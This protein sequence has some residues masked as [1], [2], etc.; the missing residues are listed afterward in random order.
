MRLYTDFL[1]SKP[2]KYNWSGV[3]GY[4]PETPGLV[5]LF[6]EMFAVISLTSTKEFDLSQLGGLLFDELQE[7]YFKETQAKVTF[8]N[9]EDAVYKVKARLE[10]ILQREKELAEVGVDMEMGVV[11]LR[12]EYLYGAIV[13]ETR[14]FI[15]RQGNFAEIAKS[16][17]DPE[18][19]GFMRSGSLV[20]EEDDRIFLSTHKLTAD[21]GTDA[22]QVLTNFK[23]SKLTPDS[24]A[25]LVIGYELAMEPNPAEQD[26]EEA[27]ALESTDVLVESEFEPSTLNAVDDLDLELQPEETHLDA[28]ESEDDLKIDYDED[29]VEEQESVVDVVR[30]SRQMPVDE[31][32]DEEYDDDEYEEVPTW[33][34]RFAGL[35]AKAM[36]STNALRAK[37][38][39]LSGKL[40]EKL[41]SSDSSNKVVQNMPGLDND[42]V[43]PTLAGSMPRNS[44]SYTDKAKNLLADGQKVA[45]NLFAQVQ[46]Q[47]SSLMGNKPGDRQMYLRGRQ[48]QQKWK[49][50]AIVGF[51]IAVALFLIIRRRGE[52]AEIARQI[53]AVETQISQLETQWNQTKA[54]VVTTSVASADAAKLESLLSS[55]NTIESKAKELQPKNIQTDKIVRL[56]DDTETSRNELLNIRAFTEPQV[57][58]DL[59]AVFQGSQP[60]S[61]VYANGNLYIVDKAKGSIYRSATG[62]RSEAAVFSSG[63]TNPYLLTVN[64]NNDL[65]VVDENTDSVMG[66]IA[67]ANGQIRRSPGLSLARIGR[68]AAI[69]VYENNEALYSIDATKSVLLKQENVSGNYQIPNSNAPWRSDAEFANAVDIQVDFSVF[70]AVKGKGVARYVAGEP[71]TYNAAGFI[72]S[73]QQAIRNI[74]AF[75]LTP[76]KLYMA[77][78]ANRRVIIADRTDE[79]TYTFAEQFKYTGTESDVFANITDIAVNEAAGS[80]NIFVL[81]GTR[82]I[83][84]DY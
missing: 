15:Q 63:L 32:D 66:I 29:K 43:Q 46:S 54:E 47:I 58:V 59:A 40:K 11:V 64:K 39:E 71:A 37:A 24:G 18:A 21:L 65:V 4:R 27:V 84:L 44:G 82:V 30:N 25:A 38:S 42:S 31:R 20:L 36:T 79:N 6:G 80:R 14:L 78:P 16:F 45:G 62:L 68:L 5:K 12:E 50:I 61:M 3:F 23:L 9:F 49:T 75:V 48:T 77:D 72:S 1:F 2:T 56:L 69:D 8:S 76:T 17:I 57:V 52:E 67:A 51:I 41:P 10:S 7:A 83:R 33:S 55:I 13:G 73:D 60:T 35:K 26:E 81:D 53:Q 28:V 74:T 19:D 22:E 34:E 70:V